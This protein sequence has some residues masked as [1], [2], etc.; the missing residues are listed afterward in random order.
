M[1]S[2]Y[3]FPV[4]LL[5]SPLFPPF[6]TMFFLSWRNPSCTICPSASGCRRSLQNFGIRCLWGTQQFSTKQPLS[7]SSSSSAPIWNVLWVRLFQS[8]DHDLQQSPWGLWQHH[9]ARYFLHSACSTGSSQ[10]LSWLHR[11]GIKYRGFLRAGCPMF[12][13][14]HHLIIS[15]MVICCH[16]L[17]LIPWRSIV[18]W[19]GVGQFC[20]WCL[21]R[22]ASCCLTR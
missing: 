9:E 5:P 6:C 17:E 1:K 16:L 19:V 10:T 2:L 22:H 12:A 3:I 11:T 20:L 4:V 14:I 7:S 15:H 18:F 21:I 13:Y 8:G